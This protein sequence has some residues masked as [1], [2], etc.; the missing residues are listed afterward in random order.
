LAV[1][2]GSS[3][4]SSSSSSGSYNVGLPASEMVGDF[5]LLRNFEK[6]IR[7]IGVVKGP[8]EG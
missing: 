8:K 5:K 2:V 1:V 4:S 6:I 7:G 3:S